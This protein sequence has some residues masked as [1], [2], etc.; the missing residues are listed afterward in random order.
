MEYNEDIFKKSAN[1]KARNV[2]LLFNIVLTASYASEMAEGLRTGQ[3]MIAFMLICWIPFI[4]GLI[5]LKIRG[6]TTTSYKNVVAVGY[7]IFYAFIVCTTTSP[8]CFMYTL[9]LGSMLVLYKDRKFMIKYGIY[10]CI[11]VIVASILKYNNGMTSATDVKDFQLQLSCV[12][13]CYGC[14]ALSINHL[15]LSDGALTDSIKGNLKRV[16]TTIGQVKDASNSI[17]DG[18]TVVR[19]LSDE[20]RQG[21][22][23]VVQSMQK[24]SENNDILQDK[25]MSSMDMTTDINTQ[26]GNVAA[27]I[28]QMVTLINESMTH[29]NVSSE[30][31]TKVVETTND[32]AALS[33]EVEKVLDEFKQEFNMVKSETGTIEGISSQ[34]NL[35]ALNASIEAARAGEAG[36][37]FAVVADEIRN[38]SMGTQN[39]SSRIMSALGHLEETSDKMT[40]SIIR[41]L[42]L[43]QITMEQVTQ[44][45][46]SVN[47]ITKDSAMLGDNIQIIDT[48]MKEVESSNQNMVQNMQ[49][50]CDVMQTMADCVTDADQ[51]TKTMLSK[52][53]ETAINVNT[54]ETTVGNL[55]VELGDGGFM[56][57]QDVAPG[58]KVSIIDETS[59]ENR[60]EYRGEIINQQEN[61]IFVALHSDGSTALSTKS[62]EH[63]YHLRIIVNNVLYSWENIKVSPVKDAANHYRLTVSSNPNVMN[64]RKYPRMPLDNPC[65]ISIQGDNRTYTGKMV[66][67]S[68]N[69]F[70]FAAHDTIFADSKGVNVVL[71]I[72][73]L[74]LPEARS[75]QGCIIRSTNNEGEYI[76]GCRM[77]EDNIAIK[78]YVKA[79]YSE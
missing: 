16:I 33:T 36:K 44:V 69:G 38:L 47:S 15:N 6:I 27:L 74:D 61:D 25:T 2:W 46:Q 67:I 20:N 34:T 12:M 10:N 53:E 9:P 58:M 79:N 78:K 26:V 64:R 3:Y 66:N 73:S 63:S 31:L 4:V 56:G 54:I 72:P 77:P 51:T 70:A 29:A 68:A 42:E 19:E 71:S 43:I 45:T 14:Y 60:A 59:K 7:G 22:H 49:Q 75:L 37:G 24:L 50:I 1:C 76:I 23:S 30:K 11:V 17:V 21:A 13:L 32:M 55:M 52:Y 18:V 35:L 8:L 48:A 39:S 5:I 62:K 57:I 41:T 28:E 40:K 65:S